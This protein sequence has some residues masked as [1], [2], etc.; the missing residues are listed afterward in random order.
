M[1]F[2]NFSFQRV[3]VAMHCDATDHLFT[4]PKS[5]PTAKAWTKFVK[6][7]RQDFDQPKSR[8]VLCFRHFEDECFKNLMAYRLGATDRYLYTSILSL[9]I[10]CL[11]INWSYFVTTALDVWTRFVTTPLAIYYVLCQSTP[12]RASDWSR[13][14]WRTIYVNQWFHTRPMIYNIGPT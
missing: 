5:I 1:F 4:W 12:Y 2:Y 3:C 11:V 6:I 8:S 10:P 9:C 13:I 7:Y 14:V